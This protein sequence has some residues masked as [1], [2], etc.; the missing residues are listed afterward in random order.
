MKKA[1]PCCLSCKSEHNFV[2]N[3]KDVPKERNCHYCGGYQFCRLTDETSVHRCS[4][5]G[6]PLRSKFSKLN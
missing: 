2:Y 3:Y 5:C 6:H 4:E 1:Y